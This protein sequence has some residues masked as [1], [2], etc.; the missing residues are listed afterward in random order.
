MDIFDVLDMYYDDPV[1]EPDDIACCNDVDIRDIDGFMTCV[2]CGTV[3]R[4]VYVVSPYDDNF[5]IK[6][7]TPYKRMNHFDLKLRELQGK[8][9]PHSYILQMFDC[10]DKI[11][12]KQIKKIL[13]GVDYKKKNRYIYYIYE[14]VN[15]TPVFKFS[16]DQIMQFKKDF[17][18]INKKFVEYSD[19]GRKNIFNYHLI[20]KH[21]LIKNG[22]QYDYDNTLFLP[23]V[24]YIR[25]RNNI[26][27]K[28]IYKN[29]N[30]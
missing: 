7:Y 15:K 5:T 26:L 16:N 19:K 25:N 9:I 29:S 11:D 27:W 17:S 12:L 2:G 8:L 1:S 4:N 3:G 10:F 22:L 18:F 28:K 30:Y 6:T 24:K 14:Y 13:K 21:I 23:K 20:I